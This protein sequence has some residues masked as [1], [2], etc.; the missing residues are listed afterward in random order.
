MGAANCLSSANCANDTN[1]AYLERLEQLN[2][3]QSTTA[4]AHLECLNYINGVNDYRLQLC[5]CM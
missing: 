1:S 4:D 3:Y 2:G 5:D